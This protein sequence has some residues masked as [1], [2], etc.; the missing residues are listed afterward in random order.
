MDQAFLVSS[1]CWTFYLVLGSRLE[2]TRLIALHGEAY[3]RYRML[4]PGLLPLPWRFLRTRDLRELEA[5]YSEQRPGR[6]EK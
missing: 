6:V 2:E 1:L 3:R 4:V 5:V